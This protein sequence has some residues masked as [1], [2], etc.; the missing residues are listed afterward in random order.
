MLRKRQV[1]GRR[2]MVEAA[3]VGAA[4]FV[5]MCWGIAGMVAAGE[6][7][8]GQASGE[9]SRKEIAAFNQRLLE[10]HQRMDNS[11]IVSMWADDGVSLL[12]ETAPVQGKQAIAKFMDDVVARMPGYQMRKIEIDFQGIETNGKWASEWAY[13]HQIVDAPEGK[14]PFEG[15]GKILL[16]LHRGADGNWRITR[17]MWNQGLKTESKQK[18]KDATR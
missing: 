6:S 12:P 15:Y 14:S 10:A 1:D 17:A 8:A 7:R 13:E 9:T 3:I 18:S 5:M 4:C 16:V 2:L 11:A